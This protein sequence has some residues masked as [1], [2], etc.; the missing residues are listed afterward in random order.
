M[1]QSNSNNEMLSRLADSLENLLGQ[2]KV[3]QAEFATIKTELSVLHENVKILSKIVRD[4][5]GNMSVLTK[6]ALLDQKIGEILK[7]QDHHRATHQQLH[8]D[9]SQLRDDMDELQ[10]QLVIMG[11]QVEGHDKRLER[12]ERAEQAAL[13][14]ELELAHTEKLNSV[15]IRAERQKLALKVVGTIV[16]IILTF[17]AGY[18]T[19]QGS[20]ELPSH[21]NTTHV[22]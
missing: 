20:A 18:V 2:I 22:P 1:T 10:R 13:D 7:W 3:S 12:E 8:E 6:I 5:D 16:A 9:I 4:G 15:H 17:L 14:K 11:A 21:Q 19:H